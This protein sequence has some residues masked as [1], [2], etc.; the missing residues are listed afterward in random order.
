[1]IVCGGSQVPFAPCVWL[2]PRSHSISRPMCWGQPYTNLLCE[3][4]WS[5]HH[6]VLLRP[7]HCQGSPAFLIKRKT[8]A[9][10]DTGEHSCYTFYLLLSLPGQ[11][12]PKVARWTPRIG[13]TCEEIMIC[14][15]LHWL[16]E[17]MTCG[18]SHCPTRCPAVHPLATY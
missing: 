15:T 5:R 3:T 11:W 4:S 16:R 14:E 9:K 13:G 2:P 17:T 6:R 10:L 12:I 18:T 8:R 1:M 7:H